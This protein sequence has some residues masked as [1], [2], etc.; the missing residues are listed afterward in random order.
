[1]ATRSTAKLST[2]AA[3][4]NFAETPE[5]PP[6]APKKKSTKKLSFCV[7]KH[8]ATALHYDFRLEHEG[9]LLSW[10]VPKGPSLNPA[11]KRMAMRTE[12]HP[13]A[14]GNFEGV[15]PSGYGAGIVVL[16]DQGTWEPEVENISAAVAKGDLKFRLHGKK[17]QGSFVL[18]R[19]R[20]PE[21][22]EVWLLIKHRDEYASERDLTV[23]EPASVKSNRDLAGVLANSKDRK[24]FLSYPHNRGGQAGQLLR[25][26]IAEAEA[27]RAKPAR[28]S[29]NG[30]SPRKPRKRSAAKG[31]SKKRMTKKK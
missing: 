28:A 31:T 25:E 5:P 12:D 6:K 29:T 1:M 18:V 17:L 24:E 13:L 22:R 23:E 11:D 9:V 3:K 30:A 15:I 16:W 2:Y 8:L 27:I 26:A 7:Q 19:I 14:Y 20:R 4:R 21:T 10:A